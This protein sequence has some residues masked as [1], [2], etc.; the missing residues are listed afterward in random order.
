M[1]FTH[2]LSVIPSSM[3]R[4]TSPI[5]S[6][7]RPPSGDYR[8]IAPAQLK[9]WK[10]R[11]GQGHDEVFR[12]STS[13]K[14]HGLIK[15]GRRPPRKLAKSSRQRRRRRRRQRRQWPVHRAKHPTQNGA[16]RVEDH[17]APRDA[18]HNGDGGLARGRADNR[19]RQGWDVGGVVW[20][21]RPTSRVT[22]RTMPQHA[23]HKDVRKWQ[24]TC[25]MSERC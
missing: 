17:V 12:H 1:R 20:W 16:R 24:R 6:S 10:T 13:N 15:D 22:M 5:P 25:P 9:G 11:T 14:L 21:V 2:S 8:S 7:R 18:K 3:T 4:R 23:T 19:Q